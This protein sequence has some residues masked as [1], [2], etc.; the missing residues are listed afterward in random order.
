MKSIAI[1]FAAGALGCVQPAAAQDPSG[2]STS[3]A[4]VPAPQAAERSGISGFAAAGVGYAPKFDGA[5]EYGVIPFVVGQVKW[6]QFDVQVQGLGARVDLFGNSRLEVGPIFNYRLKRNSSDGHGRIRQLDDVKGAAE[7]G[8]FVGY[9]FGGDEHGQG[10]FATDLSIM[11]DVNNAYDG[12]LVTGQVSYAALRTKKMFV[13]VDLQSTWGNQ[14]YQR[15]YF[16][17][18]NA[19]SRRSGLSTYRPGAGFRDVT[20]GV[21]V[22]YQLSKRWGVL[23]RASATRY[24]GKT[25][26]SSIIDAG[27]D[28]VGLVGLAL[29]Y[30]F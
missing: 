30:H 14:N 22:G 5:D 8:G 7:L 13:D 23:A 26:D 24:V 2:A 10:Q 12:L 18:S 11:H 1:L 15:T 27:S 21:T 9:R 28:T 17:V 4:S 6:R 16:G 20:A 25:A 19:E 29:S 3:D